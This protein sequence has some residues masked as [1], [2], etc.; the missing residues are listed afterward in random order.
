[1]R[2]DVAVGLLAEE[3]RAGHAVLQMQIGR[4]DGAVGVHQAELLRAHGILHGQDQGARAVGEGGIDQR[5]R[6]VGDVVGQAGR[7]EGVVGE[8]PVL[9][10]QARRPML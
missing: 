2:G 10:R 8:T 5:G 6:D 9:A 4:D 7:G 3:D 1:M